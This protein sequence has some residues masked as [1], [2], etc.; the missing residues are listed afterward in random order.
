MSE[1]LDLG[2]AD[3]IEFPSASPQNGLT[4]ISEVERNI[5]L[6]RQNF[7]GL[8]IAG[9]DDKSGYQ[10]VRRARITV[11]SARVEVEKARKYLNED[12]KAAIERNNTLAKGIITQLEPIESK[13]QEREKW[14][15]DERDR[16]E[17]EELERKNLRIRERVQLIM[18]YRPVF[19][20]VT[21]EL[22]SFFIAHE[23]VAG[24]DD[25][26]F[27]RELKRL[28]A[29]FD[30]LEGIRIEAE[31]Q[32]E[33]ERLAR[34]QQADELKRQQ[35]EL[36]AEREELEKQKR[37]IEQQ[38]TSE[39]PPI[40]PIV[41]PPTPP[42]Q[43]TTAPRHEQQWEADETAVESLIEDLRRVRERTRFQSAPLIEIKQGID[44]QLRLWETQLNAAIKPA[45]RKK[46]FKSL[47]Q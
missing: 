12:H 18:S 20:G 6:M 22:G 36:R 44:N 28:K 35:A 31:R 24:F 46:F 2:T 19:N 33:L 45:A 14:Y 7:L 32:A 5:A 13:L 41:I 23:D 42:I 25:A 37:E 9:P 47:I 39:A 38:R 34:Q 21:Y 11:K 8:S 10:A 16:I 40:L 29:E 4:V 17:R 30:V 15:E 27:E 1:T 26:D 43:E 3:I